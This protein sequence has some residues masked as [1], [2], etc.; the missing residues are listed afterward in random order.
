MAGFVAPPA[1]SCRRRRSQRS[2]ITP[3]TGPSRA[4]RNRMEP[5]RPTRNAESV[6][7]S[8]SQPTRI[9]SMRC[10]KLAAL[11]A[12]HTWRKCRRCKAPKR[13][14]GAAAAGGCVWSERAR[15]AS[16]FPPE[17]RTRAPPTGPQRGKTSRERTRSG[18][19]MHA[20]FREGGVSAPAH[21]G[22]RSRTS[23]VP[24]AQRHGLQYNVGVVSVAAGANRAIIACAWVRHPSM[25]AGVDAL[26]AHSGRRETTPALDHRRARG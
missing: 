5:T 23:R 22:G 1:Y 11:Q 15:I 25:V 2:A 10:A 26:N 12:H 13:C 8:T 24:A 14:P 3:V 6:R 20:L 19:G 9:P 18:P 16:V 17:C 21:V 4:P 7:S